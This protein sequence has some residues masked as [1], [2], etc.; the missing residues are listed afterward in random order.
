MLYYKELKLTEENNAALNTD[1]LE[2]L[3]YKVVTLYKSFSSDSYHLKRTK[4]IM[5]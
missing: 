1:I 2:L 3:L 4:T 5:L